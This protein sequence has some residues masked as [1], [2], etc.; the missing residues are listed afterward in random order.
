[1]QSKTK[2]AIRVAAALSLVS[3]LCGAAEGQEIPPACAQ[4]VRVMDECT[5]DLAN[6][7]DYN[8]PAGAA[9]IRETI[10]PKAAQLKI[11]IQQAV[12]EKGII[13]VAQQC[14][15]QNVKQ[16]IIGNM[17]GMIAPVLMNRGDATNCENALAA[18]Q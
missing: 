16:K 2:N 1:M 9:K 4:L 17:G 15:S 14:A 11:S 12:K 6:W 7:A 10:G 8:D 13:A 18:I 3:A 5:A